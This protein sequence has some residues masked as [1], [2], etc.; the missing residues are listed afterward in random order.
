[1][2]VLIADDH[3]LMRSALRMMIEDESDL[4]LVAEVDNGRD[5]IN[6]TLALAPD[7]AV[8]DLYIPACDGIQVITQ[9]LAVAPD[10][11]LLILTSSVEEGKVAEAIRAGAMGYLI[12]DSSRTEILHA[13]RE[14]G[15]GRIYLSSSAASKLA[16]SMR[17]RQPPQSGVA[18]NRLTPRE[19]DILRR[20]SA[21]ASNADIARDLQVSQTTVRSHIHNILGKTGFESRNELVMSI[22]SQQNQDQ[23]GAAAPPG[24]PPA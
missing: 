12:K 20:I 1:M 17:Q 6:Q 19:Q 22:L 13:I 5:A 10:A 23:A 3:P 21:G 8:I 9:V 24:A 7:V 4:R 18:L 14:V 2:R 15:Q 16:N 11:R